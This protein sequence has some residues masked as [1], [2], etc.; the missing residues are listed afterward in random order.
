M[1]IAVFVASIVMLGAAALR[2][3]RLTRFQIYCFSSVASLYLLCCV[4]DAFHMSEFLTRQGLYMAFF[5][6]STYLAIGA[7]LPANI[8]LRFAYIA[9]ALFTFSLIVRLYVSGGT[10]GAVGMTDDQVGSGVFPAWAL[11]LVIG[12][13]LSIAALVRKQ[14]AAII[15][16]CGIAILSL[17]ISWRFGRDNSIYIAHDQIQRLAGD[18]L[19]QFLIYNEEPLYAPA[20]SI[21]ASFTERA[22]WLTGLHF[23]ALSHAPLVHDKVFV[24]SSSVSDYAA[25][26]RDLA[27]QVDAV[28][29]LASM[30]I[31][32]AG[33]NLW[34][35]EFDVVNRVSLPATLAEFQAR[36]AA[37]PGSALP[38]L[39]G[40]VE[41]NDRIAIAGRL[42]KVF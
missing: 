20:V 8:S 42:Q 21:V 22:W 39:V 15:G 10:E 3:V 24:I 14:A 17:F 32:R 30:Q 1:H 29:P 9:A 25:V 6:F 18:S 12:V 41:G 4:F 37:I 5:M 38:S 31:Q 40:R 7:L 33:G 2:F 34:I 23:P 27:P 16:L 26:Q 13:V 28:K 35:H 36:G 11:G 19:P